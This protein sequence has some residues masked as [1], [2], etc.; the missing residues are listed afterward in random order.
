MK[1]RLLAVG[2]RMDEWIRRG[3]LTY[4]GRL[5]AQLRP[6]LQE[7]PLA[8]RPAGADPATAMD[9]EGRRLLG[10][11]RPDDFVV[12]LDEHGRQF[13]SMDLAAALDRWL[14]ARG[15]LV[16]VIGGPDGLSPEV[17]QRAD[18]LWSLSAMTLPHGL[19]RVILAEQLYRAWTIR[20]GH[21]YHKV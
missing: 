21:P 20:Q 17:R 14:A 11:L 12:A 5:P 6:E 1:I 19:V 8:T 13:P 16:F 3:Y 9:R 18:Q 4:V 15:S 10:H 2:G 7:I